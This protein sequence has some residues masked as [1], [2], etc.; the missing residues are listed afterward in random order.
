MLDRLMANEV[1]DRFIQRPM[2]DLSSYKRLTRNDVDRKITLPPSDKEFYLHQAASILAGLEL[3]EVL[4]FHW[5]GLGKTRIILTI[6]SLRKARKENL[7][8]L[9]LVPNEANVMNWVDQVKQFAPNLKIVPIRGTRAERFA[10][11]EE[12]GDIYCVQYAGLQSLMT[13]TVKTQTRDGEI[14]GK[15]KMQQ[16]LAMEF[17]KRFNSIVFDESHM[18]VNKSSL[19]FNLCNTIARNCTVR[20]GMTGTPFGRDPMK[21]WSQC[22]LVDRGRTLGASITHFQ[23]AFFKKK[24]NHWGGVDFIFNEKKRAALQ[25]MLW[26]ISIRYTAEE[27]LDLPKL[28]KVPPIRVAKSK[29]MQ[30]YYDET[31]LAAQQ[32][33]YKDY[34]ELKNRFIQMR[35]ITGGFLRLRNDLAETSVD[36]AFKENPKLDTLMDIIQSIP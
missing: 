15:R 11:L 13:K 30:K 19:V 28:V 16:D 9:V 14:K 2:R 22:Y 29:E 3:N 20:I 34:V 36:I 8:T 35:Q 21:L 23:A 10:C 1:I 6:L 12:K 32:A 17:A 5:M 27:C 7:T 18:L 26:N 4:F 33:H 31:L 24:F 25:R